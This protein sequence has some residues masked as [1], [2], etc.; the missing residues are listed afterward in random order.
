MTRDERIVYL[1]NVA[2]VAGAD[3]KVSP[4]EGEAIERVRVE[5]GAR[6]DDLAEALHAVA[7]GRHSIS[8][9]GRLS[10]Q[11]RNLEDMVFVAVCDGRL[12]GEEKPEVLGFAGQV[13]ISQDQLNRILQEAKR[14]VSSGVPES[15][16]PSCGKSIPSKSRFCPACGVDLRENGK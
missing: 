4:R 3:G 1:A 13:E 10:E 12:S 14:R 2:R 16:C 8:P 9:V 6:R 5:L 7:H 11:I 15:S